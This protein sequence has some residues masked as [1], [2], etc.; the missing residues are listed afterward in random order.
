MDTTDVHSTSAPAPNTDM[1]SGNELSESVSFLGSDVDPN[2]PRG[3]FTYATYSAGY[4]V[5][6]EYF[7]ENGTN[8][9]WFPGNRFP[10]AGEWNL[11]DTKFSPDICFKYGPDT[12]DA[13]TGQPGGS[14]ECGPVH[15]SKRR[16]VSVVEGDPFNLAMPTTIL[17]QLKKCEL[18]APMKQMVGNMACFQ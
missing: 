5:Q 15:R 2:Y 11:E 7:A 17:P 1:F 3:G 14:W 13:L 8:F 18:P 12:R 10:L 4:G 16:L 6:I 9:L